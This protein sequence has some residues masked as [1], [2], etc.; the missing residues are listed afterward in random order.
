MRIEKR[1]VYFH[2]LL[3]AGLAAVSILFLLRALFLAGLLFPFKRDNER[4]GPRQF[5]DLLS[6]V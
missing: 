6:A 2:L 5:A 1:S 3:T 4:L